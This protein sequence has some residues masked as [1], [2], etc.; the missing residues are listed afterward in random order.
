MCG[1][2]NEAKALSVLAFPIGLTAFVLELLQ[3]HP[4]SFKTTTHPN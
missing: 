1:F 2:G 3:T 4:F